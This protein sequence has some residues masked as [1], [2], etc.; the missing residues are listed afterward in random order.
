M[1]YRIKKIVNGNGTEKF[2]PQHKGLL[3]GWNYFDAS[4]STHLFFVKRVYVDLDSATYFID[5][6]IRESLPSTIIYLDRN[7][8]EIKEENK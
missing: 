4:R 6:T 7:G 3:W 2:Y 5:S 1:E 8:D